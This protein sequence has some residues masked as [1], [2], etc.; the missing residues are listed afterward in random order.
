MCT[1][2]DFPIYPFEQNLD[3]IDG[4]LYLQHHAPCNVEFQFFNHFASGD[5]I[6]LVRVWAAKK[7]DADKKTASVFQGQ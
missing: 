6:E 7:S 5:N 3:V 4:S 1:M 2:V